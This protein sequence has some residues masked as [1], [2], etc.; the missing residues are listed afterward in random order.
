MGVT[1]DTS[2]LRGYADQ[3]EKSRY[4]ALEQLKSYTNEHCENYDGIEGTLYPARWPLEFAADQVR[5]AI[6]DAS[7]GMGR[8]AKELRYCADSYDKSDEEAVEQLWAAVQRNW[9]EKPGDYKEKDVSSSGGFTGGANV[10]LVAPTDHK[11]AGDAKDGVYSALGSI[12][13]LVEKLTGIDLLAKVLP[14]VFGDWGALRRIAEAWGELEHGFKAVGKDLEAGMNTLSEHW[15][16]TEDGSGGASRAFD[17]HIRERWV[18]AYD[19]LGQICDTVQQACEQMAQFYEY[20]VHGVLFMLNYFAKRIKSALVA[21]RFS[22]T[23]SARL[24]ELFLLVT[25]VVQLVADAN[26]LAYLELKTFKEGFETIWSG[27][28]SLRNLIRGDFDAL[29]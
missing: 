3:V 20:L 9:S 21:L 19:A 16:S 7:M 24:K 26:E 5:D 6:D 13:G 8:C 4:G 12:N 1:V 27:I 22:T 10:D 11:D 28:V 18:P 15:D 29:G 23:L 17:F 2:Y 25:S 14:L